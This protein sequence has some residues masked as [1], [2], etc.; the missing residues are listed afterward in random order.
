MAGKAIHEAVDASTRGSTSFVSAIKAVTSYK[1]QIAAAT[2]AG[3][4]IQRYGRKP[5]DDDNIRLHEIQNAIKTY[6]AVGVPGGGE[7]IGA[8]EAAF[9]YELPGVRLPIV[10]V[11]DQVRI[12]ADG[13]AYPWD[14]KTGKRKVQSALQL[15]VYRRAV[16]LYYP[17]QT[18]DYGVYFYTKD[19][20]RHKVPLPHGANH[21]AGQ[22]LV[23]EE[24]V[25]NGRA[26]YNPGDHCWT[27]PYKG[28][29]K[30]A[31]TTLKE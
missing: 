2:A 26:E 9:S 20:V 18:A 6:R 15:A 22:F 4:E 1:T 17:A 19:G 31:W 7:S 30:E 11:I 21:L 12:D 28:L 16:E 23:L 5:E 14:L 27:C 25:R 24:T 29:C 8:S 13:Y 3:E 10:G